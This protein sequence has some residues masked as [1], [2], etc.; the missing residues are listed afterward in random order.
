MVNYHSALWVKLGEAEFELLRLP[1]PLHPCDFEETTAQLAAPQLGTFL[2]LSKPLLPFCPSCSHFSHLYYFF[3]VLISIYLFSVRYFF[4]FAPLLLLFQKLKA[5]Y[6]IKI[7]ILDIFSEY[8]RV[9][10][11]FFLLASQSFGG[12]GREETISIMINFCAK[13]K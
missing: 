5:I 1:P 11:S 13:K 9:V 4:N 8:L 12:K 2:V 3:I 10:C 7:P 6:R